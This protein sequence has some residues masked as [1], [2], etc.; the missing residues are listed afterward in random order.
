MKDFPHMTART[1]TLWRHTAG[2][3]AVCLLLIGALAAVWYRATYHVFP[4]MV[5]GVVHW[6]GRDYETEGEP[7]TWAQVTAQEKPRRVRVVGT[8]PP[9][10]GLSRPL[11]AAA[12]PG[13]R[14]PGPGQPCAMIVYVRTAPD[15]YQSYSL[16]GGP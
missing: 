5:P 15:R 7:E 2:S 6:C 16:E 4:G 11:L 12:A 3:G 9:I 10:F 8:Y 13:A 14:P 1:R